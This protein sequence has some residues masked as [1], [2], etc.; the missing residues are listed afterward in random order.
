MKHTI[1]RTLLL[2]SQVMVRLPA[3]N[4]KNLLPASPADAV[5]ARE[6]ETFEKIT[7]DNSVRAL[8]SKYRRLY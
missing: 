4:N 8:W 2:L 5:A 3:K 6:G 1:I 7:F